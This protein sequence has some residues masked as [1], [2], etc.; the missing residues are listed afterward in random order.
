MFKT[1]KKK[2]LTILGRIKISK[3]PLFISYCPTSYKVRGKQF[4]ELKDLLKPGYVIGRGYSDYLD[5]YFIPGE[6]SHTS[7]CYKND[8]MD[9]L[10]I[11]AMAHGVFQEDLIDFLRC[12]KIIVFKPKKY[13]KKATSIAK[14]LIGKPYDFDFDNNNGCYYCHEMTAKCFPDLDVQEITVSKFL[15]KKAYTIDSF[16]KSND[17]EVVYEYNPSKGKFGIIK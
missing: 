11:H 4:R 6:Y 15:N 16:I 7:I 17:F 2:I 14:K 3:Y 10:V 5:G 9:Q 1:I 12:D 8:K 13:L